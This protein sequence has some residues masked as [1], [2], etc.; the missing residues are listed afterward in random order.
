[1][2]NK[3]AFTEK[4]HAF[5]IL[6]PEDLDITDELLDI[7]IPLDG[8]K[9]MRYSKEEWLHYQPAGDQD[10]YSFQLPGIKLIFTGELDY[11]K[12]NDLVD[13]LVAKLKD[14]YNGMNR[15]GDN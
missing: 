5:L 14:H 4:E 1:M 9:Y 7:L 8:K 3:S 10:T 12:I 13:E 11:D 6:Y 2:Y 15:I